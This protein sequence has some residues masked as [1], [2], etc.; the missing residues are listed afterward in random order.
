MPVNGLPTMLYSAEG[1]VTSVRFVAQRASGNFQGLWYKSPAESESGWGLNVTHQ[2][3]VIFATWFTYDAMGRPL[4]LSM[5]AGKSET[6][7]FTG[8]LMQTSGR[9]IRV[10]NQLRARGRSPTTSEASHRARRSR[11]NCSRPP[12]G[13]ICQ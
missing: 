7:S 3:D 1:L 2:G 11:G 12:A 8:S 9:G 13:T 10:G 4:W 6:G 5:T